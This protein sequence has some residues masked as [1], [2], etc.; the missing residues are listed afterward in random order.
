MAGNL[1]LTFP[2]SVAWF[3]VTPAGAW[4][5]G[6]NQV[7]ITNLVGGTQTFDIEGGTENP[8]VVNYSPFIGISG[9]NPVISVPAIAG[10]PAYTIDAEFTIGGAVPRSVDSVCEVFDS[11]QIVGVA[12]IPAGTS[13]TR[14]F[15]GNGVYV[16]TAL[17]VVAL[18]G[19][20]SG[21][22]YVSDV[23]PGQ[24]V[25]EVIIDIAG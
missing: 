24:G 4:P 8:V 17:D 7:T 18:V 5:A 15:G 11:G 22:L 9:G 19:T 14:W 23:H 13:D 20:I 16:Q 6:V 10:G 21:V 2:T 25:S 3:T 12:G 1:T